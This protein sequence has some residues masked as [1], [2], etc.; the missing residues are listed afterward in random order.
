MSR[1]F[2]LYDNISLPLIQGSKGK[3]GGGSSRED[4][5]SLFSTDVLFMTVG[6]GEGPVYRINPNGPQDIEINDGAI[7]DLINID[8]N[9]QENTDKFKTITATGTTTQAPIDVFGEASV[10]PQ[11]FASAVTLRK[12]NLNG[13]PA[14]GITLQE[15]S[16]F[17]WDA[18]KFRF[19]IPTLQKVDDNGNILEH[20]VRI[21]IE[22]FTN[23][24]SGVRSNDLIVEKTE[25]IK[26]KT[27]VPFNFSIK[28]PIPEDK[29][30][31]D[32][33]LFTITKVSNDSES[34]KVNDVIKVQGWNEINNSKQAYPRTALIGYALKATDEHQ[35]GVPTFTAM[36]KGLLVK[37]PSNYNQPVLTDGQIDWREVEV[38][39][40]NQLTNGYSL[41]KPGSG[42]K[43]TDFDPQIYVGTWDGTFVYSWTQ[44]PVWIIYDIL[45]NKTYG[46][47]LAEEN[48]DKYKFF[49]VAQYCDA[50]DSIT[51]KFIGVDALADG[52]FRSKPRGIYD[53]GGSL[54]NK[55]GP[56]KNN[57]RGIAEGTKIKQ[58]RFTM[59][60]SIT[61]QNQ[62]L[63]L[64]NSLAASF[65][66]ALVYSLGKIS[67]SVDMPDEY[68]VMSF[69]EANI[70]KG[71]VSISGNKESDILSGVDVS[72]IDPTNH[73]KRETVRVD[74]DGSNDGNPKNQHENISSLDLRGVTRRSQ[75]LRY[76]Q[77]QIASSKY[78][79]RN[80][81]F[82]TSTDA[83]SLAPGDVISVAQQS[84][85][86]AYGFS[87]KLHGDSGGSN[88]NIF[89]EHFT[90]P[91]LTSSFFTANTGPIVLR[92][93]RTDRD[94]LDLY[95]ISNTEFK[96]TNSGNVSTGSDI[97]EINAD[98]IFNPVTRSFDSMSNW[99]GTRSDIAPKKGDLW[100]LGYMEDAGD[101]YTSKSGR[102]FKVTSL[103][104]DPDKEEIDISAVEYISNVYVDSDTFI[105]YQPTA[106]TDIISP[107]QTP[108]VPKIDFRAVPRRRID[109]S[110]VVDGLIT[111]TTDLEG[112][113]QRFETEYFLSTP[114]FTTKINNATQSALTLK[115]SN[116]AELS[117]GN[118]SA[119]I[120][121]KNGFESRVGEIR[122][123][124]NGISTVDT[125]GGTLNGNV[126]LTLE[127]LNVAFDENFFTHVLNVNDPG[128]F[129]NLKGTDFATVPV[130]EK[131][132]PQ[133]LIDF[134]GFQTDITEI[135][136][137]IADFDV[138][139][140]TIK[141]ENKETGSLKLRDVIDSVPFFVTINQLLD[142]R[143]Y[144]NSSFYVSGSS[145]RFE[146]KGELLPISVNPV[147]T[148]E[149][150]QTPRREE[151]ISFFVDGIQKTTGQ[152]TFNKNDSVADMNANIQYSTGADD[153]NYRVVFDHYT[154]P[155]IEVGDNVQ[156]FSNNTFPVINTS[157]TPG[158]ASFNGALTA[159]SIYR[160]E[161]G[162]RPFANLSGSTFTNIGVNPE[163]DIGNVTQET[164]SL[165]RGNTSYTSGSCTLDYDATAFPGEFKLANSGIYKLSVGSEFEKI[166][167]GEDFTV[168]DLSPGITTLRARNK[169]FLG[170]FSEF[171]TR[172]IEVSDLPIQKVQNLTLTESLYREQNAGVAVRVTCSFDA[173]QGQEVTDYEISYRLDNIDDV[174]TD[175]GGADLTSFNTVKVAATGVDDDGKIR[176]TVQG[177]NRGLTSESNTIFFRVTPLNKSIRGQSTTKSLNIVGKTAPPSN[178]L[179]FT[180]GQQTDQITFFWEYPRNAA[181]DLL[182]LDLKEV[183]IRR[184][185]GAEETDPANMSTMEENFLVGEP[186]VTV[187]AGTARKSIPIDTFGTFTYYARTRD[188]SGNLSSSDTDA[189]R[190]IV[191]TTTRP[192]R[193]SIVQSYS[194]DSPSV[195]AEA[196][197]GT[198]TNSG[199]TNYPSFNDSLFGGLVR[200]SEDSTSPGAGNPSTLVDNSNGSSTGFSAVSGIP[201]D[202]IATGSGEYV[203]QIRD[204]GSVISGQILVDFQA[205]QV[206]QTRYTDTYEIVASGVTENAATANS[207]KETAFG[208]IGHL[209]GSG[210]SLITG[211]A[212]N[213]TNETLIGTQSDSGGAVVATRV[214]AI[215]NEG[216][217][218]G[219]VI[220]ITG[221]SKANPA[222][223]TTASEHGIH[224]TA[225][226]I[227]AVDNIGA[228][229]ASR[230]AGTYNGVSGSSTGSGTSD[231]YNITVDGSGAATIVIANG[232]SGH[233]VD[234]TITIADSSLGSGGAAALTFDVAQISVVDNQVIIHSVDTDGM[235][236][237][238]NRDVF[239]KRINSTSLEVY[240]NSG[241][242]T[243]LDSSGFTT[244]TAGGT[245]DQGDFANANSHAFIAGFIDNDEIELAEV[246]FA[247]GDPSGS[248]A[249]SNITVAGNSYL[250]VDM[251]QYNDDTQATYAGTLGA[252]TAQTLIRTSQS[253]DAS[254]FNGGRADPTTTGTGN[255]ITTQFDQGTVDDGFKPYQA[256]SR[257]FR[258]F[259]LKFVVNNKNPNQFDF[260][261]DKIR[262]TVEKD[263][264]IFNDT[265]TYAGNPT[266]VDMS[267]AGFINR[268]V[269]QIQPL[270]TATAQTAVVTAAS[271][272]SVSFKLYDVENN[273]TVSSTNPPDVMVT[274]TGV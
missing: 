82:T 226:I 66:G 199:E 192:S 17:A 16:A 235:D 216:Q 270:S 55:G 261:I 222:V 109:G 8:G 94:A 227:L 28:V 72:Y 172:Q 225:G 78:L 44:N 146:E 240:T 231:T 273:L 126:Q 154:V 265:V 239:L 99:G 89:L 75:A 116:A 161:L 165:L 193:S 189:V 205:S 163:G 123:L 187:S 207:M 33:Y 143:F 74:H 158:R 186:V 221:I 27:N 133:G 167:V 91:S 184:I 230:T 254:L 52:S 81:Q 51:G 106:Y 213:T 9:G 203:T 206:V 85:G 113:S 1:Q 18:L 191:I 220:P 148:I 236:E 59:D 190:G 119:Q 90:S 267:S 150:E 155:A 141:F 7:L 200:F 164:S 96:L 256:G 152:F 29:L 24:L 46:V 130:K 129:S 86:I 245:I 117:D 127:G 118:E 65:R 217:Y 177:I 34:S 157:Y 162:L 137:N 67:L 183:V 80:I 247:N 147:T 115:V 232:G 125:A 234:D 209:V 112:Y 22:V 237:M 20:S 142:A 255:V 30:N 102:L 174:G 219:N 241:L 11:N 269:I 179:R 105:D 63:D 54:V 39:R 198:N 195:V 79:K 188:T 140:N 50:C 194:E 169:N 250:L 171:V 19:N 68:P 31:D 13:I 5:N 23:P 246:Y 259:Q 104:R 170:R 135:S 258:Q 77:Y 57:Q 262:Y 92:V 202:I 64:L 58:R 97:V 264:T 45:T 98:F 211:S 88:S 196:A 120:I 272:T 131:T 263:T 101:Y 260:T 73:F 40:G 138:S 271:A 168:R 43:L 110:I 76:A 144:D 32:G 249:F 69:T 136:I 70:K 107:F 103:T 201:S 62:V 242:T 180:G 100:A 139:N 132:A 151:F 214:F 12:G 266:T 224:S 6:L 197:F 253:D 2:T 244:Y 208:G 36:V 42:T 178:I 159:N 15:T 215:W 166:N 111:N 41:Q 108:P 210:N 60:V 218:Q 134:V 35:G 238:N 25:K 128:V 149:L 48:I 175:D 252:V 84:S 95:M 56:V 176:F 124:C 251:T 257:V 3:G 228:A 49:Q 87:G 229:D 10:T 160:I 83:L 14:Q 274:A 243:G 204:F 71:S 145:V 181:G 173:I 248:N 185:A 93:L 47:G 61:D 121:G 26:G 122:L 268:P 53:T 182:D 223:L 37:V 212:F 114:D 153:R 156:A 233:A 4:P 21:K 38:P